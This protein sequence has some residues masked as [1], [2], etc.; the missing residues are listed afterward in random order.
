M[1]DPLPPTRV[2]DH[3]RPIGV[4]EG[5]RVRLIYSSR[6]SSVLPDIG[7]EMLAKNTLSRGR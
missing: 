2:A 1:H 3:P 5:R 7:G 6:V 4:R